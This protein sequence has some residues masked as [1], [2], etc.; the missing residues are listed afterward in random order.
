MFNYEKRITRLLSHLTT[1]EIQILLFA[2]HNEVVIRYQK[3]REQ[4]L[5]EKQMLHYENLCR[6]ESLAEHG[7]DDPF[8]RRSS[9]KMIS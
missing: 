9:D 6:K 8:L 2:G 4:L 1:E 7:I 5:M 3:E